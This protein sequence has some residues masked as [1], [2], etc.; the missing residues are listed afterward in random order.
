M[1]STHFSRS[2]TAG[3]HPTAI[4]T[5]RL[6]TVEYRVSPM[7]DMVETGDMVEAGAAVGQVAEAAAV[8]VAAA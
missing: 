4:P 3:V 5:V 1:A 8:A 7:V 6:Y 2:F